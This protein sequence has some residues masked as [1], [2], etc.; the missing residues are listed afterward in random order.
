MAQDMQAQGA[1]GQDLGPSPEQPSLGGRGHGDPG[2]GRAR[3]GRGRGRA[4]FA[5]RR[6]AEV[7]VEAAQAN[8]PLMAERAKHKHVPTAMELAADPDDI[9]MTRALYG[10]RAQ[11][12]INVLLS[13]NAHLNW[14]YPLKKSIP[15]L[16]PMDVREARAFENCCTA[17]DMFEMFERVSIRNHKSFLPHGAC[18]KVSQDILKVFSRWVTCGPSTCLRSSCKTRRQNA[19]HAATA[20]AD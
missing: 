19:Q 8:A 12:I 20:P 6:G 10:S 11:T 9:A 3:G 14:Y 18:Y 2:R 7:E 5:D 4:A 17:I 15:F 16:A 1:Q 13:F